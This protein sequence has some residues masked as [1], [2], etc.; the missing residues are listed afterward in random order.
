MSPVESYP[1]GCY[2]GTDNGTHGSKDRLYVNGDTDEGHSDG[3]RPEEHLGHCFTESSSH[4]QYIQV[5]ST[6]FTQFGV[7]EH[8]NNLLTLVRVSSERSQCSFM[9]STSDFCLKL[10]CLYSA[11]LFTITFTEDFHPS[12]SCLSSPSLLRTH[13]KQSLSQL[14]MLPSYLV[15]CIDQPGYLFFLKKKNRL[16]VSIDL[17]WVTAQFIETP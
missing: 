16:W 12:W 10:V 15:C 7:T 2:S 17:T 6:V 5:L 13:Q 1:V 4:I 9:A 14:L 3:H 8:S 11:P